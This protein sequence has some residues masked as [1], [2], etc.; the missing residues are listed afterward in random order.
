VLWIL[1]M[2]TLIMAT[3]IA[4]AKE[5]KARV[6]ATPQSM[7]PMQMGQDP[8]MPVAGG[9]GFGDSFGAADGGFGDDPFK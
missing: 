7:Q 8:S 3:V 5:K 1:A 6:K 4:G 2:V 9:D